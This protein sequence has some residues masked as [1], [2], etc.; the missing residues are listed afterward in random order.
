[1]NL[2]LS[3][4]G[5]EQAGGKGV[6]HGHRAADVDVAFLVV[7]GDFFDFFQIDVPVQVAG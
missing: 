6:N 2:A 5:R 1:M 4:S 3:Q 7:G